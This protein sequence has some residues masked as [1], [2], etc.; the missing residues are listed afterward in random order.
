MCLLFSSLKFYNKKTL[1]AIQKRTSLM[2]RPLIEDREICH[3][4]K[5]RPAIVTNNIP[6]PFSSMCTNEG[7]QI[8]MLTA[9]WPLVPPRWLLDLSYTWKFPRVSCSPTPAYIRLSDHS[10]YTS[11]VSKQ[12]LTVSVGVNAEDPGLRVSRSRETLLPALFRAIIHGY[13]AS[14][15]PFYEQQN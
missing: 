9:R 12:T 15:S 3:K 11:F 7:P 6:R 4:Q 14:F 8:L 2:V 5:S 1:I 10:N 13:C